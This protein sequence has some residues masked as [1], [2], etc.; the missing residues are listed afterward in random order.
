MLA[1]FNNRF[2]SKEEVRISPDD[3]GFLFGDGAYEVIR[4]YSGRLFRAEEHL[5]R[6]ERS[7][8]ELEIIGGDVASFQNIAATLLERN[9]LRTGDA[10]VYMQ[11]TRGVAPRRHSFPEKG[12]PPTVYL[13]AS[14]LQSPTQKIENGITAI[15]VPD[16]RWTRCDIKSVSL[17]ANV[18]ANQQAKASGAEEAIFVR[19][20][21]ITEGTHSNVCAVFGGEFVTHPANNHILAGITREVVL[22]LC[23]GLGIAV[24]ERPIL[25]EELQRADELIMLGTTTEVMPIV[26]VNDQQVGNGK[27]GPVTRRL[28]KAFREL[29]QQ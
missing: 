12:T 20:D 26:Q 19:G 16:I 21:A 9:G 14:V 13:A 28:Q 1:Y 27:P 8:R 24:S 25:A 15:L 23:C 11:V 2:I 4:S 7:L 18:L 29:T 22:N 10:T 6:L 17:V 5:R 3:R